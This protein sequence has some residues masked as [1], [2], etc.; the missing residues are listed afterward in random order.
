MDKVIL[1]SYGSPEHI[2]DV[3][4]YLKGIFNGKPVPESV[5]EENIKKYKMVNGTSPSNKIIASIKKKLQL[6]LKKYGDFEVIEAF[7]HWKPSIEEV[8][9]NIGNDYSHIIALP[10]FAFRSNN[11]KNSYLKPIQESVKEIKMPIRLINGL[12]LDMFPSMWVKEMS[13]YVYDYDNFLYTAHSLPMLEDESEYA[14]SLELN[15]KKIS[16][17]MGLNKIYTGFY[18]QG[19]HGKWLE[20]SIYSLIDQLKKKNVDNILVAPIGFLYEHLEILYDLDVKFK[21]FLEEQGIKY[22]RARTPSDSDELIILLKNA[23]MNNLAH[24]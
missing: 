8:M 22:A 20:P 23:I 19:P 15:A 6:L 1:L 13:K 12:D 14:N 7:K 24:E 18:S 11:I 4:E 9:G 21:G 2:E 16:D 17:I 5:L 3:P 10:L